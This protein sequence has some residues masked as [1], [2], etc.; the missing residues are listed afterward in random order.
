M[1][2]FLVQAKVSVWTKFT[3]EIMLEVKKIVD[4]TIVE[5]KLLLPMM[6][7]LI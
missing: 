4:D 5:V 3:E 6:W 2:G 7:F 1:Y